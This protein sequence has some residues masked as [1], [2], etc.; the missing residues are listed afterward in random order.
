MRDFESARADLELQPFL[1]SAL[2]QLYLRLPGAGRAGLIVRRFDTG[3][4]F[5]A[6]ALASMLRAAQRWIERHDQ[7]ARL[8]RVEQPVEVGQDFVA[9]PHHVYYTSTDTYADDDDPPEVPHE[10]DVMRTAFR[11]AAA[12]ASSAPERLLV[13][14][15]TRATLD[16]T[17][18]TYFNEAEGRFVA[19]D[20][21]PRAE[22]LDRWAAMDQP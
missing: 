12:A 20:L 2:G 4:R 1:A 15:L 14:V 16:P 9:R 7:L 18:K 22:E 3:H 13:A 21:S 5:R 19:V 6:V 11:V 10:L 17:G 8:L